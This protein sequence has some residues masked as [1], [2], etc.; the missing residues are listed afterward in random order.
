MNI[1]ITNPQKLLF[2]NPKITKISLA[3]YYQKIAARMLPYVKNRLLSLICCPGGVSDSCFFKKHPVSGRSGR[4]TV[5]VSSSG[6]KE[7]TALP[8]KEYFYIKNVSDLIYEVQNNAIEF[9]IWGSLVKSLEKPDYMVFDLD[10]DAGMDLKTIRR[11]VKDLKN[12]LTELSLASYLKTSGGK[13]YH[14]VVPF[15]PSAD[16]EAFRAF[17]K[18]VAEYME[19]KWPERYTTNIR[20]ENRKGKIF[21]DW[22]RNI[23]AATSVAP[24]SVRARDGA[25]VS[26]PIE[27]DEL[28]KIT[29]DGASMADAVKRLE[30]KDPWE[31]F[32]K[33]TNYKLQITNAAPRGDI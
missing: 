19:Q 22:M 12:V 32:Y 16:W 1:N 21:I 8:L 28:D 4:N 27:W 33:I 15:K 11:G 25:K 6:G 2:T 5:P 9:H 17:A 13:G 20:K 23:R 14:V 26:M 10:P 3:E 31:G 30:G 7:N 29:P 24:Y 18:S